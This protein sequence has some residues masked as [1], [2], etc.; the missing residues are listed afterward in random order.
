M[1]MPDLIDSDI[2]LIMVIIAGFIYLKMLENYRENRTY[3]QALH[4]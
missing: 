2:R 1:L 4:L 3:L